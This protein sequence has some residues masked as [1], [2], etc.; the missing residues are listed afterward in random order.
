[1]EHALQL[2]DAINDEVLARRVVRLER[3]PEVR[4]RDGLGRVGLL[5]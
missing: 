4:R 1:V 2:R 3:L 5:A